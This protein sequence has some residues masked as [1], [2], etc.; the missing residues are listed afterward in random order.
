MGGRHP[1]ADATALVCGGQRR[2]DA[3]CDNGSRSPISAPDKDWCEQVQALALA[4]RER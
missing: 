4:R 2:D 3:A 1:D